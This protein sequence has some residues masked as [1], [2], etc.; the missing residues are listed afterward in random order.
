MT[1]ILNSPIFIRLGV[2]NRAPGDLDPGEVKN[3]SISHVIATGISHNSGILISGIPD[4]P[5]EHV[6]LED[7][8]MTF[9]GGGTAKEAAMV[10]PELEDGYPEPNRF[11]KMPS[12]GLYARH[13]NDLELSNVHFDVAKRDLRPAIACFDV[14][15]F[16]IDDLQAKIA[17]GVEA[18]WFYD[19]KHFVSR[20]SPMFV[21]VPTTQPAATQPATMPAERPVK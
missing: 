20:N 13:V 8:R 18:G 15:G 19:V 11:G 14:N 10:P 16:Q 9:N 21:K 3:I 6:R 4:Y 7:I 5:I 12:Y 2:R 17:R 1:E